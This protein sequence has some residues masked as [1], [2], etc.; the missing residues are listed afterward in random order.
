MYAVIETG[1]KQYRVQPG[2]VVEIEKLVAEKGATVDFDKILFLAKPSGTASGTEGAESS[3]IWLGKPYVSGAK[4]QGEIVGQGRGEKVMLVKMK[5]R[6]QYRRTQG[7]R[8]ELTHVLVMSVDNG[9][10]EKL[11]LDAAAKKE[12][13]SK[14]ITNLTPKGPASS[15]KI[16]GSRKR[17]AAARAAGGA[18]PKTAAAPAAPAKAPKAEK[19]PAAKKA[20]A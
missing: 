15:P 9:A 18:A 19:K 1:G 2:D 4:V 14:F 20:K 16:L 8:Q 13:L 3:Q 6:K 10:G 7:H 5:R 11:A 12:R 17:M